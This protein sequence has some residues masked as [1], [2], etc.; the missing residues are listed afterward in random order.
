MLVA[1][2]KKKKKLTV[3]TRLQNLYTPGVDYKT[4]RQTDRRDRLL[5]VH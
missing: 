2:V 3:A 4:F 1:S 5:Y